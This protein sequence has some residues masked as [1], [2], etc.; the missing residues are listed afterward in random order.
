MRIGTSQIDLAILLPAFA[1]AWNLAGGQTVFA[2]PKD[3]GRAFLSPYG[4][5]ATKGP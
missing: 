5:F 3:T 1:A 2:S 4:S